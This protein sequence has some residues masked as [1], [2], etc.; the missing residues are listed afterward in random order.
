MASRADQAVLRQYITEILPN[1]S[2]HLEDLG[3]E[4]EALTF[5]WFLSL[6]TDC[7]SAEALYRVWDVVLCL[8]VTSTV[9]NGTTTNASAA[10]SIKEADKATPVSEDLAS[11]GG[12]GST[13]LFQVALALLKLNE[14]QLL[15]TCSTPAALYTYINHQM[16]NHAISI[17]GLIQASEALRNMV[18]REDV[19][20]RRALALREMR[21]FG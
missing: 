20:T 10:S 13:F 17:D 18:R 1:L 19:I 9:Q 14:P 6:F 11:G 8:N 7:L 5:Q 15:T 2:S 16:T 12:G 3:I 4:L 21:E